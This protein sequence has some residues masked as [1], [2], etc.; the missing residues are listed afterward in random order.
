MDIDFQEVVALIAEKS[1]CRKTSLL[2]LSAN[3]KRHAEMANRLATE[4]SKKELNLKDRIRLKHHLSHILILL[5]QLAAESAGWSL[6]DLME[7]P[8]DILRES[9]PVY[10]QYIVHQKGIHQC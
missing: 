4:H 7:V 5:T 10:Y 9:E 3:L 2:T 6:V 1:S 8:I